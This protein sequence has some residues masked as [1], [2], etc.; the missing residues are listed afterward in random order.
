MS[1]IIRFRP[2]EIDSK[3]C[4]IGKKKKVLKYPIRS[5]VLIPEPKFRK[6]DPATLIVPEIFWQ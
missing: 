2:V 3:I 5:I 4:F 6:G 1:F